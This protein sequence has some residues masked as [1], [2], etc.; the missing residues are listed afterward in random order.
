MS[1]ARIE[2]EQTTAATWQ[3]E[4]EVGF[5]QCK[6]E[7]VRAGSFAGIIEAVEAAHARMTGQP[8]REAKPAPVVAEPAAEPESDASS[9]G[10]FDRAAYQREYMRKR[11][12]ASR[13]RPDE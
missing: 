6:R 9:N 10:T 1:F 12:A 5:P 8:Q 2:I 3:A 13:Q 11:R 4:V 7:M